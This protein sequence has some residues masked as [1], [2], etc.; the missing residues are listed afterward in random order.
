M[1]YSC[2]GSFILMERCRVNAR[3]LPRACRERSAGEPPFTPDSAFPIQRLNLQAK[4]TC[5]PLLRKVARIMYHPQS[6]QLDRPPY[7]TYL[8]PPAFLPVHSHIGAPAQWPR[9]TEYKFEYTTSGSNAARSS[10]R[11][12]SINGPDERSLVEIV[13]DDAWRKQVMIDYW[14]SPSY[15][16]LKTE[17]PPPGDL[18]IPMRNMSLGYPQGRHS[19]AGRTCSVSLNIA[20]TLYRVVRDNRGNETSRYAIRRFADDETRRIMTIA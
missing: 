15:H 5:K 11:P 12:R 3:F 1:K 2:V 10:A 9:D 6:T 7:L 16:E 17:P 14:T 13:A 8:Q 20:N 4:S 19:V 18:D